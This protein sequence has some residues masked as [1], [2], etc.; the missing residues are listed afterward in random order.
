MSERILFN[1]DFGSLEWTGTTTKRASLPT[2]SL[3]IPD[4]LQD[5]NKYYF[6]LDGVTYEMTAV[7]DTSSYLTFRYD[8][9]GT[10]VLYVRLDKANDSVNISIRV[11]NFPN[12]NF[13]TSVLKIIELIQ[14]V[15]ANN[16]EALIRFNKW[17]VLKVN[18][19]LNTK[20]VTYEKIINENIPLT[21]AKSIKSALIGFSDDIVVRIIYNEDDGS[22][23]IKEV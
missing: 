5:A 7:S 19:D 10:N 2:S 14:P 18:C 8:I 20:E 23:I 4:P 11:A 16:L 13:E 9:E 3:I 21:E 1:A 17:L 22:V 6:D 15:D 12:V